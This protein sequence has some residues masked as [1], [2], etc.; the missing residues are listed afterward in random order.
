MQYGDDFYHSTVWVSFYIFSP[1][2]SLWTFVN[3]CVHSSDSF[4][5]N[6][7]ICG[8]CSLCSQCEYSLF[9]VNNTGASFIGCFANVPEGLIESMSV[10]SDSIVAI[11]GSVFVIFLHQLTVIQ[12]GAG[13]L[14]QELAPPK[15]SMEV[16]WFWVIC[17][18]CNL[19]D[20]DH[21]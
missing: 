12:H 16:F 5:L 2:C 17:I 19:D 1:V 7:D 9:N 20:V 3:V 14:Q 18:G 15:F 11:D 4:N 13:V 21:S 8:Q 6:T 10:Y